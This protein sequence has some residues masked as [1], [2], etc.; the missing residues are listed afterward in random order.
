MYVSTI[1]PVSESVNYSK[2]NEKTSLS[3][4]M[5]EYFIDTFRA[6][7]AARGHVSLKLAK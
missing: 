3:T 5:L 6:L 4:G 7:R 1:G 2:L